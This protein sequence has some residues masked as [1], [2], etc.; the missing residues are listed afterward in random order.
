MST[1]TWISQDDVLDQWTVLS[2]DTTLL[3]RI[4]M[5][6]ELILCKDDLRPEEFLQIALINP[7][8]HDVTIQL[9]Q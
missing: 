7:D 6:K 8:T 2:T 4:T 3:F 1:A 5:G 9:F